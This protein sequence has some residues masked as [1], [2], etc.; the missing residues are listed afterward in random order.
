MSECCS[1]PHSKPATDTTQVD[2]NI[3]FSDDGSCIG[4]SRMCCVHRY[5]V[6]KRIGVGTG[7][8]KKIAR[9]YYNP[10]AGPLQKSFEMYEEKK[11]SIPIATLSCGLLMKV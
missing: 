6:S 1:C 11:H 10:W 8:A 2:Y 9:A 4:E 5:A 7:L 3:P